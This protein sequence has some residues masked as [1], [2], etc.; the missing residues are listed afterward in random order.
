MLTITRELKNIPISI[1]I[2]HDQEYNNLCN[3]YKF[4]IKGERLPKRR[5]QSE[6]SDDK[7][8]KNDK[9]TDRPHSHSQSYKQLL[10]D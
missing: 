9:F 4:S 6:K 10:K 8:S 5:A 7:T 3:V 1:S 2:L